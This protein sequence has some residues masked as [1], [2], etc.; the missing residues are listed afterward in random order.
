MATN[1]DLRQASVRGATST[2]YTY[3]ED[4]LALF[5][6]AG[7]TTG[8]FNDRMLAWINAKLGTAYTNVNDAMKAYAV[9]KSATQWDALGTFTP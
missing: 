8:G 5:A 7:I 1:Q 4:W 3:N 2:A 9:A 6:I